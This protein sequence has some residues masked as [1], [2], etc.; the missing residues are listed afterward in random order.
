MVLNALYSHNTLYS[1]MHKKAEAG[2]KSSAGCESKEENAVASDSLAA[3]N[4]KESENSEENVV[5][6]TTDAQLQVTIV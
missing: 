2:N 3:D 6:A 4:G 5:S 1:L